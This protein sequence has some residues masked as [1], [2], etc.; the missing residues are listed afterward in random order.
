MIAAHMCPLLPSIIKSNHSFYVRSFLFI[1]M[2]ICADF[3]FFRNNFSNDCNIIFRAEKNSFAFTC[4]CAPRQPTSLHNTQRIAFHVPVNSAARAKC[5]CCHSPSLASA[6][7]ASRYTLMPNIVAK[8]ISLKIS[9]ISSSYAPQQTSF[10]VCAFFYDDIFKT[11][12]C[13]SVSRWEKK[14]APD[15]NHKTAQQKKTLI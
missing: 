13:T 4:V 3:F 7:P 2:M 10:W 9:H 14:Y 1:M 15:D 11:L 6:V 5:L 12:Q 8:R